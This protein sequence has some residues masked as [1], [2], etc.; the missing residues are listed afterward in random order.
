MS[1]EKVSTTREL[2]KDKLLRQVMEG[3]ML[4][5]YDV[6]PNTRLWADVFAKHIRKVLGEG[7][8]N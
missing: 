5:A 7:S 2:T 4:I 8:E 6:M 3:L 1:G